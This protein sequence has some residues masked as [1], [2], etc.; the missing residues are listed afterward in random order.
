MLGV[1]ED[2]LAMGAELSLLLLEE[3]DLALFMFFHALSDPPF[4]CATF[5]IHLICV[6]Q[7]HCKNT[8]LFG[9]YSAV[10]TGLTRPTVQ[11][12]LAQGRRL[13]DREK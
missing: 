7:V 3:G 12:G 4:P 13:R 9:G 11:S 8:H 5:S 1:R 2:S 10:F 6:S